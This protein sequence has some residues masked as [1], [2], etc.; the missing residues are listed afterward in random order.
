MW[1]AFAAACASSAKGYPIF[2]PQALALC[3]DGLTFIAFDEHIDEIKIK[4]YQELQAAGYKPK[5]EAV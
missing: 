4:L 1:H 5:L 2:G 3:A